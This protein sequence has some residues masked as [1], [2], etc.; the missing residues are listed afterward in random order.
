MKIT[1]TE[2]RAVE[3]QPEDLFSTAGPQYWDNYV[4]RA[5]IGERVYIRTPAPCPTDQENEQ[6]FRITIQTTPHDSI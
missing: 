2:V 6:I 3:L 4:Q 1:A 5:S